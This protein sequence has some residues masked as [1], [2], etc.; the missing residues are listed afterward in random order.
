[1][2]RAAQPAEAVVP[3]EVAAAAPDVVERDEVR[4]LLSEYREILARAERLPWVLWIRTRAPG[5]SPLSRVWRVPRLTLGTSPMVLFHVTRSV[6]ALMRVF[7]AKA[8]LG[9]AST[10]TV[11]ASAT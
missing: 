10:K 9:E 3:A 5:T 4:E 2:V 1:M 8:A 7:A 11:I 6:D